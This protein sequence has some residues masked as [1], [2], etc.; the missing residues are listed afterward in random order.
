MSGL[1]L[2][3][4]PLCSPS[5]TLSSPLPY[6]TSTLLYP[7][8]QR[9]HIFLH[10]CVLCHQ[11]CQVLPKIQFRLIWSQEWPTLS[12]GGCTS[13]YNIQGLQLL[14]ISFLH[15]FCSCFPNILALTIF[16]APVV[17]CSLGSSPPPADSCLD[18][19]YRLPV[20]S[21]DLSIAHYI[22]TACIS[23]QLVLMYHGEEE[24]DA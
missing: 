17:S 1:G 14:H 15:S 13:M 11:L 24:D 8:Y 19:I 3:C 12:V 18:F 10:C 16:S 21:F 23:T 7:C 9:P 22:P 4:S 5:L 2:T 6:P 20:D